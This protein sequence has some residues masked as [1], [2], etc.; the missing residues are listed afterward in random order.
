MM[1]GDF[2]LKPLIK[3]PKKEFSLWP[4]VGVKI[5]AAIKTKL[6]LGVMVPRRTLPSD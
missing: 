5:K 4:L 2:K 6:Y 1:V 3:S